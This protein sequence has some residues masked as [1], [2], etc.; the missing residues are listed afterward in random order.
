MR[1]NEIYDLSVSLGCKAEYDVPLSAYTTFKIGGP[2]SLMITPADDEAASVIIKACKNNNIKPFILGNGSNM[3]ISDDGL[4]TVV[5]NMCR[6][7]TEINNLGDGYIECNAGANLSK[8]CKFALEN[9][10]SGLEFAFGIPGSAGGAAYMNAGAYGGEMKDVLVSCTHIDSNGDF[11]KLAGEELALGYRTSAYEH[12]GYVIT[13]LLLKLKHGNRDEI[14]ARMQ[15]LLKR[16]KDKQ[17]LEYPSA[18][19]TFKRPEG[20][21]AAA[22][23]DECGL[24]GASV[25]DAQ[26]SVKHAGFVINRGNAKSSDVLELIRL[27]QDVVYKEKGV[28]IEPEVRLIDNSLFE[29]E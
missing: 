23:I 2:A 12:N 3:L 15:E 22:L 16:R 29:G 9:E 17:P 11:G 4:D 5:I 20:Y 14:K 1:F 13:K 27:V 10:L 26:V 6:D 25:G 18:G 28:V 21:F 7:N 8:V 19:S 24:K